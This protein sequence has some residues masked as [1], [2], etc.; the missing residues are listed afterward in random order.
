[1]HQNL[2]EAFTPT[3]DEADAEDDDGNNE[4]DTSG[5]DGG[6]CAN[7]GEAVEN[8]GKVRDSFGDAEKSDSYTSSELRNGT[9]PPQKTLL[10]CLF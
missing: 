10:F 5:K 8:E 7:A 9:N 4:D 3:D 6:K 1:M 2:S